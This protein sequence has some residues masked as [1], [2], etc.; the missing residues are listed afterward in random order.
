MVTIAI[1]NHKITQ[2]PRGWWQGSQEEGIRG[3]V[4]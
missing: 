4:G 1:K 2:T 3:L